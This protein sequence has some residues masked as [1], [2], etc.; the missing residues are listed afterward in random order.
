MR[1]ATCVARPLLG[2]G[3]RNSG[4][5]LMLLRGGGDILTVSLS[6]ELWLCWALLQAALLGCCIGVERGW[7]GRPAGIRTMGLVAMGAALFTG[8]GRL[9]Y[10]D[11]ARVAAQV[12]S[13]VGFIGAGVVQSR[14]HAGGPAGRRGSH[15]GDYLKGLT[16]ASAIWLCAGVGVACGSGHFVVAIAATLLA[17]AILGS[18]RVAYG[19]QMSEKDMWE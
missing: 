16:T 12:A 3:A 7:A 15:A 17:I 14:L 10:S 5:S 13:G 6:Q 9:S 11:G 8:V 19:Q 4:A 1:T 2:A 18:Y